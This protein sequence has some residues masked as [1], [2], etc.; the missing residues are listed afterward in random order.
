MPKLSQVIVH[1]FGNVILTEVAPLLLGNWTEQ[2]T[3]KSD[4]IL[5][6][7]IIIPS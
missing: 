6:W 3:Y 5:H 4:N 2:Q 7:F 1:S